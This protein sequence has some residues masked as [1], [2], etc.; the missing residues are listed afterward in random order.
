LVNRA[1]GADYPGTFA[2][3][4][5]VLLEAGGYDAH[6]LFENLELLRTLTTAGGREIRANNVFIRRLPPTLAHFAGQRVRQAY[7]DF[8][9]PLRLAIELCYAPLILAGAYRA[10]VRGRPGLA[11]AWPLAACAVA[12]IGRR[13]AGG[14]KVFGAGSALWAPAWVCER[15][16]S[17][18]IAVGYR[19]TGGIPYAGAR[20]KV[21]A[22][23]VAALRKRLRP[24]MEIVTVPATTEPPDR[25]DAGEPVPGA[26]AYG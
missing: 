13:R 22:N 24:R 9:Q 3:R 6:V 25:H 20:L 18:W 2:L 11:L 16:V 19:L 7:D 1:F 14:A 8:A 5:S 10:V 12:E 26:V 17:I 4:R 15:A 23:T 21:S